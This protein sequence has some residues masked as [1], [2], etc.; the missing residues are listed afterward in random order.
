ADE[1]VLDRQHRPLPGGTPVG[2]HRGS[3]GQQG[4]R[5]GRGRPGAEVQGLRWADV[6]R[7]QPPRGFPPL[8]RGGQRLRRQGTERG[9]DRYRASQRVENGRFQ[10]RDNREHLPVRGHGR[11]AVRERSRRRTVRGAELDGRLRRGGGPNQ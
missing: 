1:G 2:Q 10:E 3:V 6:R 8:G 9:A 4:L 11:L 7:L 5:V